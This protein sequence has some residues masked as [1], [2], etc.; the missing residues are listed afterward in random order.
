MSVDYFSVLEENKGR[1]ASDVVIHRNIVT[2]VNVTLADHCSISIFISKLW[3][4]L[5]PRSCPVWTLETSNMNANSR[6]EQWQEEQKLMEKFY[7][8]VNKKL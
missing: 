8:S 3:F 4:L 2:L 6:S 5:C 7:P 1:D